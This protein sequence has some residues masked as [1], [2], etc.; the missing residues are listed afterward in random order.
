MILSVSP[1][2]VSKLPPAEQEATLRRLINEHMAATGSRWAIACLA[3]KR[4]YP[5][6]RRLFGAP[7]KNF[8]G[9]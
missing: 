2:E 7:G 6:A 3:V 5:E 9:V 1:S 4:K 8:A